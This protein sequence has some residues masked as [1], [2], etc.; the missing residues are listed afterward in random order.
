MDGLGA[1][2][3]KSNYSNSIN[4]SIHLTVQIAILVVNTLILSLYNNTIPILWIRINIE[5]L[6]MK[7]ETNSQLIVCKSK[8]ILYLRQIFPPAHGQKIIFNINVTDK[9]LSMYI[10]LCFSNIHN[11]RFASQD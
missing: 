10:P 6:L 7:L 9:E 11:L 1:K 8:L 2:L 4:Q 3:H 5:Q